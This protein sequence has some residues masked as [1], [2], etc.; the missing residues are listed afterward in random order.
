VFAELS[1]KSDL[2]ATNLP[3]WP[4]P[5]SLQSALNENYVSYLL[6]RMPKNPGKTSSFGSSQDIVRNET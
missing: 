2:D 5:A 6:D 1:R 3:A 4:A